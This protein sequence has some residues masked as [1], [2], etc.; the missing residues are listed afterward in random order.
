MGIVKDATC[1]V[2]GTFLSFLPLDNK[3]RMVYINTKD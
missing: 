3:K 1:H 2:G